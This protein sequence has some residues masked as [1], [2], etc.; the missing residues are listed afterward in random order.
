MTC[1]PKIYSR[2]SSCPP[3]TKLNISKLQFDL[4]TVDEEPCV[5]MSLKIPIY[6]FILKVDIWGDD[7]C[8]GLIHIIHIISFCVSF[9]SRIDKLNTLACL[10]CMGL[11]SSA[12]RPLQ[13]ERRGHGFESGRSPEKLFC[14]CLNC[15]SLQWSHIHFITFFNN[16]YF[17]TIKLQQW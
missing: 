17:N 7:Y 16:I 1:L 13:C 9:L 3:S 4:E 12:G 8:G 2:F 11:Y 15:D 10:Q 5:D 6:L 14:N